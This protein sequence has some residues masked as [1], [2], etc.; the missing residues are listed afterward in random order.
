MVLP[1]PVT[2]R[3]HDHREIVSR[4]FAALVDR[5]EPW[6]VSVEP[7]GPD[8]RVGLAFDG[9]PVGAV[10]RPPL[11]VPWRYEAAAILAEIAYLPEVMHTPLASRLTCPAHDHLLAPTVQSSGVLLVCPALPSVT[12][13]VVIPA[14]D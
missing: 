6:A 3:P 14:D 1:A 8:V 7:D 11:D 5:S 10:V 9:Q 2:G 13:R 12:V 4:L